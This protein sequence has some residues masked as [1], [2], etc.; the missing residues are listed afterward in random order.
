MHISDLFVI[1]LTASNQKEIGADQSTAC[2]T[3]FQRNLALRFK[4]PPF[5]CGE[6]KSPGVIKIDIG[7]PFSSKNNQVVLEKLTCVIGPLPRHFLTYL[8]ANLP[9][10]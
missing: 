7:N 5:L 6:I 3:S 4:S 10:N 8:I 1:I 9:P 2:E